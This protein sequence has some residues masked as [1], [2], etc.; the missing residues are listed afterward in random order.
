M[1][2][3]FKVELLLPHTNL[4]P[5]WRRIVIPAD[6]VFEEFS[7]VIQVSMGWEFQH[8]WEFA[9][10]EHEATEHIVEDDEDYTFNDKPLLAYEVQLQDKFKN[11]G[12]QYFYTYDLSDEWKHRITLEEIIADESDVAELLAGEGECPPED[13]GGPVM[14]AELVKIAGNPEYEDEY[15][16]R[17]I[18][19]LQAGE[20]IDLTIFDME[21]AQLRLADLNHLYQTYDETELDEED[22][23]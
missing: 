18:L 2:L 17:E 22:D 4:E 1:R 11:R 9:N 15:N 19:N 6:W 3:Q 13:I 5:V 23:L 12:D 8:V 20:S 16:F 14:Y 7:D 21:E 10:V